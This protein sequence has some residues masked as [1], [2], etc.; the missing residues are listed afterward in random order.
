MTGLTLVV[1]R[2]PETTSEPDISHVHALLAHL[3]EGAS[4]RPRP[5]PADATAILCELA[6]AAAELASGRRSR[7]VVRLGN[8]PDPWEM[9]LERAG[10]DVLVSVFQGGPVPDVALHERRLDGD[11]FAGRVLAALRALAGRN[12][13]GRA[14]LGPSA[15]AN[16]APPPADDDA[17]EIAAASSRRS[18][19]YASPL[20]SPM[21]LGSFEDDDV[22]LAG[23]APRLTAAIEALSAALPFGSDAASAEPSVVPVDPTGDVSIVIAADVVY[24]APAGAS[25][26]APAVLR[27]DLFSLLFRGRLRIT[28]GE[29]ARELP[30]VFVFLL[31]EQ[32]ATIALEAL[33]AWTRG[34]PYYRR[35][36]AF[37]AICGVKLA[38]EGAASLTIGLPRRRQEARAQTWTFPAV[39]VGALAQGVVAFGRALTR[40]LVRRDR[41]QSS[42][43][44]LQAFRARIRELGARLRDATFDDSKINAAPEGYRAFAASVRPAP[45]PSSG[46]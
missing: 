16:D 17:H 14:L 1:A 19:L 38:G 30:D 34:R 2:A 4:F 8:V 33:E 41:A 32:L 44:R 20:F 31:A 25:G 42:N 46:S 26:P 5:G 24:R 28:V 37:G 18:D 40:S 9:G 15:S 45:P 7:A 10:R 29:H 3:T 35:L 39:D 22:A 23:D 43:L 21:P 12:A 6:G 27:A 36:T 13:P 11:A